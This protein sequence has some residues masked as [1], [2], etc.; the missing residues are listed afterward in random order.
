MLSHR[1]PLSKIQSAFE[2]LMRHED[3]ACKV[4]LEPE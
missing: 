1:M 4:V 3:G 2:M